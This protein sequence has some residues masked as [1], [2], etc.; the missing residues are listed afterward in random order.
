MSDSLKHIPFTPAIY[1]SSRG[2]AQIDMLVLHYTDGPSLEECVS[3]FSDP[4]KR[5]SCHYIVGIDGMVRQMVRDEDCAWHCGVSNW[6]DRDGCNSWSIGIE[7]VNC[8]RLE[9]RQN[10][11]YRWPKEYTTPYAGLTP[12]YLEGDWWAPYPHNQLHQVIKLSS[13]LVKRYQ[14][15][16]E[17]IV[18]HSG[19]APTRKIDPGPAFP[20]HEFK[21]KIATIIN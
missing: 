3:I 20:W 2:L 1:H 4:K 12:I 11:F 10:K 9:K 6:G 16:L 7:I 5:V 8:G 18:R 14:I 17:N 19:I 13:K 21:N 15:P